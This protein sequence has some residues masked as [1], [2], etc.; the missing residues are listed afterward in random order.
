MIESPCIQVCRVNI[1][2]ICTGCNRTLEQIEDWP[3]LSDA[4][5]QDILDNIF[6][7]G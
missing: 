4:E 2:G 1:Q 5:K 7:R 3:R 6:N